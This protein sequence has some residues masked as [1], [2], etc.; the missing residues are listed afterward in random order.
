[1]RGANSRAGSRGVTLL[2]A[3]TGAVVAAGE[4]ECDICH[5]VYS[6]NHGGY[7]RHRRACE[8]DRDL[9]KEIEERQR[10]RNGLASLL[11][12]YQSSYRSLFPMAAI[13]EHLRLAR[14][15]FDDCG[16]ETGDTGTDC[17]I[18]SCSHSDH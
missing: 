16:F 10:E 8:R 18:I 6:T 14:V 1:M 15:T 11:C 2:S 9:L 7:T 13:R 4:V 17:G 3:A 12:D 5:K